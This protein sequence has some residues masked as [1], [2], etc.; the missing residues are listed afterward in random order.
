MT[1]YFVIATRK[2]GTNL[3][4]EIPNKQEAKWLAGSW[5]RRKM[6]KLFIVGGGKM[7]QFYKAR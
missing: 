2:N 3:S 7:T 4:I 1:K 6:G 5:Q